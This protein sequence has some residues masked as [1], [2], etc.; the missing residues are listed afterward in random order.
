[1]PIKEIFRDSIYR[2]EITG[3]TRAAVEAEAQE[4][5]E[6]WGWAYGPSYGPILEKDGVWSCQASRYASCD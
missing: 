6:R 4:F 2:Y 1:M 3:D 5:V